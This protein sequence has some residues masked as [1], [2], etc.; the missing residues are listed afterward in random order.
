M[1]TPEAVVDFF[2]RHDG[3]G[4][5]PPGSNC[6]WITAW[7]GMGCAPWCAMTT[8]RALAEAGFGHPEDVQVPGVGRTTR[9][10][11]AYVPYVRQD[12]IRA[13]RY[14]VEPIGR[15]GD[16][17]IFDWT[18]DGVGDHIGVV[19]ARLSDGTYLC[20]EGNTSGNR[21]EQRRRSSAVIMGFCR[22]PY[23]GSPPKAPA[24]PPPPAGLTVDGAF[25]PMTI[26]A[27]QRRLG[28]S[29][30]GVFGPIS[31]R[32]LQRHLG[33]AA[34]GVIGPI[35]VRALQRR[36][37]AAEDGSWGPNTTR[38]LQRALNENRF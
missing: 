36:V 26:K 8:S 16:L 30:D 7:Y 18:G 33:V 17:V 27:L 29:A 14:N 31:R 20:R 2:R 12:Y 25:G 37:G 28:V 3:L 4:E 11:H 1:P 22:P 10:G 34:D 32:A 21:L 38:A 35:T 23:D 5:S 19:E 13:G 24:P 6:N 9:H 15:P